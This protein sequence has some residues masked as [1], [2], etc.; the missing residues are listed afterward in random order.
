METDSLS[1]LKLRLNAMRKER[2]AMNS[3]LL[4]ERARVTQIESET[5]R[6][7]NEFI[8]QKKILDEK[9]AALQRYNE[10][11]RESDQAYIKLISNSDKL[12]NALETE[13]A[14]IS[15]KFH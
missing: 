8:K 15:Q 14:S 6:L 13:Y 1:R 7:R 12:I 3:I 2:D 11:I 10:T 5:Q 9:E 4:N